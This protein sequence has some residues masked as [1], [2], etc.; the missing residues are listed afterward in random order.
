M[1]QVAW[2]TVAKAYTPLRYTFEID[3]RDF[4]GKYDPNADY[5]QAITNALSEAKVAVGGNGGGAKVICQPAIYNL[6]NGLQVPDRV[7]LAGY[8]RSTQFL[9]ASTFPTDGTAMVTLGVKNNVDI[10]NCRVENCY[11]EGNGIAKVGLFT[12]QANENCGAFRCVIG[13]FTQYGVHLTTDVAT[14]A[15]HGLYQELEIAAASGIAAASAI[16]FFSDNTGNFNTLLRCTINEYSGTQW[17]L[18][19]IQINETTNG[20]IGGLE[21]IGLHLERYQNGAIIQQSGGGQSNAL[22]IGMESVT[23]SVPGAN[24]TNLINVGAGANVSA[25]HT[26][27]GVATNIVQDAVLGPL[28][29]SYLGHW[30]SS[31]AR[32]TVTGSKGANAALTSLMAGLGKTTVIDSTT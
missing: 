2:D 5:Y 15:T 3:I 12:N 4:I 19:G 14:T 26:T 21:V 20:H 6:S 9:A 30:Y 29:D 32:P 10:F 11:F 31:S 23:A 16:G 27:K 18:Y 25:F 17:Q 8:G 24:P 22:F 1:P 28:T 13:G 7:T